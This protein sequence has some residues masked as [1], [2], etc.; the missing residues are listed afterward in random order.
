MY[1][2]SAKITPIRRRIRCFA[3]YMVLFT[4]LCNVSERITPLSNILLQYRTG[5]NG[6][7]YFYLFIYIF[8]LFHQLTS[9][10]IFIS[11]LRTYQ[12]LL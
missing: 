4:R 2:V 12:I 7:F 3:P 1:R 5:R 10:V 8:F 11:S 6:I 9:L